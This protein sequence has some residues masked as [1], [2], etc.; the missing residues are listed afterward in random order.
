MTEINYLNKGR[1]YI[2]Q[3]EFEK[4]QIILRR[5]LNDNPNHARA[6]ELSG[7][8]VLKMGKV[9]EA[10][11]RYEHASNNYTKNEMVHK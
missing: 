6:L 4:A 11:Q 9:D 10:I 5:A 7:D 3:G 1:V 8:L 2:Q